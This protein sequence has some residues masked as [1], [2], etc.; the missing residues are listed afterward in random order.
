MADINLAAAQETVRLLETSGIAIQINVTQADQH[1]AMISKV[2]EEWGGLEIMVNNAG[3]GVAATVENTSEE[4]WDRVMNVNLKGTFLGMKYAIP[5]IRQTILGTNQTG[6]IIN[7]SS[8]AAVAAVT[9]RAAYCASKGGVLALSEGGGDRPC[10]RG[11]A[12]QCDSARHDRHALGS[13]HHRKLRRPRSGSSRDAGA[14]TAW[15]AGQ[16]RRDCRDGS[17]PG[18][19]GSRLGD[20]GGNDRGRGVFCPM[21][22]SESPAWRKTTQDLM[23]SSRAPAPLGQ[24]ELYPAFKLEAGLIETGFEALANQLEGQTTVTIDGF[25]GVFWEDLRANL[26]RVLKGRGVRVCWHNIMEAQLEPA[27]IEALVEPFLGG[28]DPLFGTRFTGNLEQFFDPA[29]LELLKPDNVA[30]LNIVYGCGAALTAFPGLLIY[31]DLPKNE[32]QFRA[33]AGSVCNLACRQ[34]S[35]HKAMYKR[36]YFVDWQVLNAHKARLLERLDLIV[37][38]QRPD[39]ICFMTGQ[40]LRAGLERMSQNFF[41]VRPWFEP[42]AWGGQRLKTLV[43]A[44]PQ[45]APNYAWSFELI[46]PEN[47]LVFESSGK[48]LEVSFDLLMFFDHQAVL[49]EAAARFG[50]DF[51]IRFDYLDTIQGGNLSLP[52][53]HWSE[54]RLTSRRATPDGGSQRAWRLPH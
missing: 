39:D 51:P 12:G 32:L 40:V 53:R 10:A 27:Q 22:S 16:R 21:T 38:A 37:D 49:G 19:R 8:A 48:L 15:S 24:Y 35:D 4:D 7:I 36:F 20:R 31:V 26:E 1:Q 2:I 3:V 43:P 18:F 5:A 6:S 17:L 45:T 33:R 47:G 52:W 11:C 14:A 23:P 44:L 29:K 13:G 41:R 9:N 46:V 54:R 42:G 28:D 34:A 30:D 25:I 50:F